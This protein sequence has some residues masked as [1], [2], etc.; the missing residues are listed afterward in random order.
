MH[1]A[2][3]PFQL[4]QARLDDV[5][6][7]ESLIARSV[8][9]LSAAW[10]SADQVASALRFMFGVDTQLIDDGTY[11]VVHDDDRVVAAGLLFQQGLPP[12]GTYLFKHSLVQDAAYGTLLPQPRRPIH[13]CRWRRR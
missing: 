2:E 11:F 5:A 3:S 1:S 7:I 9:R 12:H 4:R 13:D 10:Y 8:Q 6:T